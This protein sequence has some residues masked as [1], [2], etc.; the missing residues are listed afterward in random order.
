MDIKVYD[1][2]GIERDLAY[3]TG[4]YGGFVIRSVPSDAGAAYRIS[5]LR[6]RVDTAASL[7]VSVKDDQG[8]SLDG[9]E[10]AWYWPDAPEDPN[11]GPLGG[12]P[13]QMRSNRCVTGTTNTSGDVGFAMG[14]GAYYWPDRGEIGPHGVWIYGADTRS[15]VIYGLGMV[16]ATNH[17]HIDVEFALVEEDGGPIEPPVGPECPTEEILAELDRIEDAVR[18]I[19]QL[20]G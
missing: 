3:L 12:V 5:V 17:D 14:G 7:I 6:E 10:I 11:A 2:K 18:A 8:V 13:P 15:E 16:A 9:I 4:K 20:L 1:W 19:R